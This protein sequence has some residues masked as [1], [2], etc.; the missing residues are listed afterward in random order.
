MDPTAAETMHLVTDDLAQIALLRLAAV[1][2]LDP[3]TPNG[4]AFAAALDQIR[5]EALAHA[6]AEGFRRVCI[7]DRHD[8]LCCWSLQ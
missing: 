6:R 7:Y 2:D 1:L 8:Q 5:G 4:A 3:D